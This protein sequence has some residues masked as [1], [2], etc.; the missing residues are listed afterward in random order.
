MMMTLDCEFN[1][2]GG[3][4]ISMALFRD[5]GKALYAILPY[6]HMKLDPWVAENVIP[7]LDEHPVFDQ[8]MKINTIPSE[9]PYV[10]QSFLSD[11]GSPCIMADWPDDIRYF[12]ES[13]ITGPGTM[14]NLKSI[15]F[16][17][18]RVDSWKNVNF[19]PEM[20]QHNALCDAIA[21]YTK[22]HA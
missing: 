16:I 12:C 9:L 1:G 14:I 21:L 2:F 7:I 18:E 19:G 6:N 10:I 8:L 17:V 13:V 20:I 11:I 5:D 22:L 4:L 15:D 3:E